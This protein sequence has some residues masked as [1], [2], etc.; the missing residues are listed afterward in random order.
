MTRYSPFK[1]LVIDS[2]PGDRR[3]LHFQHTRVFEIGKYCWQSLQANGTVIAHLA[4]L[5]VVLLM[6]EDFTAIEKERDEKDPNEMPPRADSE[7]P[8]ENL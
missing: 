5:V 3:P 1:R 4:Y 6:Q 2:T 7:E 8:T